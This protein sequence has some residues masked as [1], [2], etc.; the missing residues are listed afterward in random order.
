MSKLITSKYPPVNGNICEQFVAIDE[1]LIPVRFEWDESQNS[2][3]VMGTTV[4]VSYS[5]LESVYDLF[6]WE[7]NGR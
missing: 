7:D 6:V 1:N 2:F 4:D 3:I 5:H